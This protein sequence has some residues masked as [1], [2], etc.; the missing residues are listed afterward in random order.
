MFGFSP[1]LLCT[2]P[3]SPSP[4][5]LKPGVN[6]KETLVR[7][8]AARTQTRRAVLSAREPPVAAVDRGRAG[9]RA[10][11]D[12]AARGGCRD[13]FCGR[14]RRRRGRAGATAAKDATRQPWST[15]GVWY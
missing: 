2:P 13:G 4:I 3:L 10:S 9:H 7:T 14:G 8:V 5:P 15:V 1:S 11:M 6:K 12:A